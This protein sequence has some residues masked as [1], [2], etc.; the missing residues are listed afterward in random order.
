M[1]YS[2]TAKSMLLAGCA[3]GAMTVNVQ[4]DEL[5]D[6]KTQLEAL[7]A[8]VNSIETTGP[9]S[10]AALADG[11]SLVTFRRGSLETNDGPVN[12]NFEEDRGFTIAITPTTDI[13]APTTEVS[14]SGYVKADFIYDTRSN[15]G[16][17]A[18]PGAIAVGGGDDEN[19]QA[20][21]NQSR[22]RIRSRSDTAVGEIRTL[23]EGDFE[24]SGSGTA[25]FRLRHAWGEW[26]LTPNMTLGA[27]QSWSTHYHFAGEIPTVDFGGMVGTSGFNQSRSPQ[28][29]VKS[30]SDSGYLGC[31]FTESTQR[32]DR[33][34]CCG[35]RRQPAS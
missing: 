16:R 7:Q 19:F 11:A 6:L 18:S 35:R 26:D 10:S 20:H 17:S 12:E 34:L 1:S 15:Q 27:G 29:Q 4:A 5:S 23:I 9:S 14:V 24:G 30:K 3:I 2:R 21:A 13:P 8:R 25:A 31:W 22:F 32:V 28:I 33:W